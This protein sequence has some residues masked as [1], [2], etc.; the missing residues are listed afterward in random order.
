VEFV[1]AGLNKT[2]G[3]FVDYITDTFKSLS[4]LKDITSDFSGTMQKLGDMIY[5]NVL[6]RFKALGGY[7]DAIALALKGEFSKAAEK[8]FDSAVQL[9]TGSDGLGK[10]L[11]DG[12][13]EGY[14]SAK[15]LDALTVEAGK[16]DISVQKNQRNIDALTKSLKDRT[17]SEQERIAIANQIAD[18]EIKNSDIIAAKKQKEYE[19]EQ[20]RTKGR[21]LSGEEENKLNQAKFAIEDALAAKKEIISQRQT[22]INILL[23]KENKALAK[24][25]VETEQERLDKLAALNAQYEKTYIEAKQKGIERDLELQALEWEK[26][27]E[28]LI[29]AHVSMARIEEINQEEIKAIRDRYKEDE[30]KKAKSDW[31]TLYEIMMDEQQ[32]YDDSE[33]TKAATSKQAAEEKLSDQQAIFDAIESISSD[34]IGLLGKVAEATGASVEFSKALAFVDILVKQALAIGNAIAGATAAALGTGVA[35]PFSLPAFIATMVGAVTAVIGGAIGLLAKPVPPA[36]KFAEGGSVFDIGGRPHSQG[37]TLFT[38]SD[39][40]RFEA[41]RG[42]KLFV[43]KANASKYIDS[44]GGIN[45]LFGGRAWTDSPVSFAANG[46]QIIDGGYAIR[47]TANESQMQVAIQ[48]LGTYISNMPAPVVSVREI[49]RVNKNRSRAI[50][51]SEL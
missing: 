7:I 42:E 11:R 14:N 35:A 19:I 30:I 48:Q 36:P 41:E 22:R 33:R 39:G 26:K 47:A 45:M 2:M 5:N 37:G 15:A 4:F 29:R 3:V 18:L 50:N 17:K 9:A 31:D 13:K 16:L 32:A 38:G 43:M 23:D 44:L 28:E 46:G 40:T 12:A 1:L 8:A 25:A 51:V 49:D 24:G 20:Q 6:N 34:T 10:S 27:K 21:V